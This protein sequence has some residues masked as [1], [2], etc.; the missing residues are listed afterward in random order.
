[1]AAVAVK[2]VVASSVAPLAANRT[3]SSV[4]RPSLLSRSPK[5]TLSS[6]VSFLQQPKSKSH[7]RILAELRTETGPADQLEIASEATLHRLSRSGAST[8]PPVRSTP[9]PLFAGALA[10]DGGRPSSSHG[11][12]SRP[13]PNRFPEQADEEDV[14]ADSSSNEDVD[15]VGEAGSDWGGMSLGGYGTEDEEERKASIWTGIRG[16]G[17]TLAGMSNG[18][19]SP[20]SER[21]RMEVEARFFLSPFP[22]VPSLI[23]SL[24]PTSLSHSSPTYQ[25]PQVG[26]RPLAP[27]K[28]RV[29][30]LPIPFPTLPH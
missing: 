16:S 2:T 25:Q 14:A 18:G 5:L 11:T 10:L 20:G 19:R 21:G 23:H 13:T 1:M 7:L 9:T 27:A 26:P 6:R 3:C 29:R 22:S 12:G 8:V 28:E 17:A 15:D 24:I 4:F 30:A